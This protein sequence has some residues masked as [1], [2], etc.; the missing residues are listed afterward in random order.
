GCLSVDR[1]LARPHRHPSKSVC[2]QIICEQTICATADCQHC[3]RARCAFMRR[4]TS[5]GRARTLVDGNE[6]PLL[7]LGVWQVP[8]GRESEKA[9]SWARELGYRHIDTAQAY[10]NDESVG[11]ALR[12]SGVP[13]GE[14]FSTT[15]F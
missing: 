6:I 7:G 5:D 8:P 12:D 10:R 4:M 15:K 13:R 2:M 9:V 3:R 1:L 11:R 14:V